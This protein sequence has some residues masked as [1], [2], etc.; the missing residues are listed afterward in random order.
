MLGEWVD[1]LCTG[2]YRTL[3]SLVQLSEWYSPA[4]K[5]GLQNGHMGGFL[6]VLNYFLL[7]GSAS[8]QF[9]T[10]TQSCPTLC[11]PV[12]C[13]TPGFPVHH[14][15]PEFAQTHMHQAGD[16]IQLFHPVSSPSPPAFNL[17]HIRFIA[18]M[19]LGGKGLNRNNFGASVARK[20]I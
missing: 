20:V 14:K 8:V 5:G 1:A 17:S 7:F 15:L 11:N 16:A 19:S 12:D 13:S 10:V 9:S 3:A 6:R 18:F 2:M 4:T